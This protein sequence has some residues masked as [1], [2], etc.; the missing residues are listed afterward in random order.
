MPPARSMRASDATLG[1]QLVAIGVVGGLLS[2]L[3]GVGG[4]VVM[5]PLLVL[6]AG[7]GSATRTPRPL[8]AIIPISSPGSSRSGSRAGCTGSTP[9][10]SRSGP[11]SAPRS[12]RACSR[13]R[14]SVS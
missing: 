1:L 7:S 5:V 9:S 8:G 10:R 14:T 4:G 12:E 3:L 11:S 2:G 13:A 6:W